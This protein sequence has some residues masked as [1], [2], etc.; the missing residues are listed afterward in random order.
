MGYLKVMF[1]ASPC[2]NNYMETI[3]C[4]YGCGND[5]IY[6]ISLNPEKHCC[7]KNWQSCPESKRKNSNGLRKAI[8][9]GRKT[10]D[11]YESLSEEVKNNMKWSKGKTKET[12]D[13]IKKQSEK[14]KESFKA[15]KFKIKP[16][17]VALNDEL[18]YKR[19]KFETIDS[20]GKKVILESK[21]EII[22]SE[23]CNRNK[24]LWKKSERKKLESGKSFQPDFYLV[25]YD[26]HIDPKSYYWLEHYNKNQ[27]EKIEAYQKE[28]NTKVFIFWDTN[29]QNWEND[30]LEII[31]KCLRPESN[32]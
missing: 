32:W 13:R 16:T 3:K 30:L 19:T 23:I 31:K 9:E 24:I 28:N 26:I 11:Y 5:G 7:S 6:L 10:Y 29:I 1:Y 25:E 20:F 27:L 14:R 17:G 15:G 8:K 18:R 2:I 22:F 21:N 12:D 4:Y